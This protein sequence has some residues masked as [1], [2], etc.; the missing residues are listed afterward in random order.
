MPER[1]PVD[2]D[3]AAAG[4]GPAV[5][6]VQDVVAAAVVGERAHGRAPGVVQPVARVDVE[7]AQRTTRVFR[8]V[9]GEGRVE[10]LAF[11]PLEQVDPKLVATFAKLGIPM[12]RTALVLDTTGNTSSASIPMPLS[13][14]RKL[15][16][17][18][19]GAARGELRAMNGRWVS[20]V[21]G[22]LKGD[23]VAV[24]M[25]MVAMPPRRAP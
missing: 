15:W 13:A 3:D 2:L 24:V 10:V 18:V 8:A 1:I 17:M 5:V 23:R 4:I 22:L 21:L 19:G 14:T 25:P 16:T 6:A 12:E 7:C 11:V 20:R 9:I